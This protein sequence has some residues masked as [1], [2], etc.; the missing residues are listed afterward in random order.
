MGR[1][2]RFCLNK[3]YTFCNILM[4]MKV[5]PGSMIHCRSE[6]RHRQNITLGKKSVLYKKLT[7][8][9]SKG[10]S[11][12]VGNNSHI[13]PHA[14]CLVE[15]QNLIIG[16]DVAIGPYCSFFCLSNTYS[17]EKP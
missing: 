11:L 13:A 4:G 1:L 12:K 10:G 5:G 14:Y 7:I 2:I 8:Y 9:I 3:I 17:D 16:N 15:D 6:L